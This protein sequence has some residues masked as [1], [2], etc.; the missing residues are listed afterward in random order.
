MSDFGDSPAQ[1]VEYL[2]QRIDQRLRPV[3]PRRQPHV[4]RRAADL[5]FY[6]LQ[7]TNAFKN[8]GAQRRGNPL[9][10]V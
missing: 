9:V 4:R 2:A 8:V 6:A 10:Q 7:G 3:L 1:C 5:G